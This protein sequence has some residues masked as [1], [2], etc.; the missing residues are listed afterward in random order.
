MSYDLAVLA[1]D[2]P[3]DAESARR[4]LDRCD[5]AERH[6]EG[7]LDERVVAFYEGLRACFPD[8]PPYGPDSPWMSMPLAVGIDHVI[9]CMSYSDRSAPALEK[10]MELSA[11]YGLV[12]YDPQFDDVVLSGADG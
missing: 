5:S 2:G 7:D 6:V 10:I 4:M 9:I 1:M 11:R 12:V 3:V 8:H